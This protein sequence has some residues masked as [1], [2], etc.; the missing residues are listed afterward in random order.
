MMPTLPPDC[1]IEIVPVTGA[2]RIGDLLVFAERQ[3]LVVHRLVARR[4]ELLLLQGDNRKVP[5]APVAPG[6]IIGRVARAFR[7][8]D[9]IYPHTLLTPV[10]VFWLARYY[11]FKVGRV[12]R[13]FLSDKG[14]K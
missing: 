9:L 1:T 6:Q 8:S 13:R 4:G 14:F 12:L 3:A 10:A 11:W 2:A 5:D 7:G